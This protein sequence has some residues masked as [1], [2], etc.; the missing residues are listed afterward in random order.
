V[1]NATVCGVLVVILLAVEPV[2]QTL[3]KPKHQEISDVHKEAHA[4][5]IAI[6]LDG[7]PKKEWRALA[8]EYAADPQLCAKVMLMP[9]KRLL[10]MKGGDWRD[11]L[12]VGR[13]VI[14]P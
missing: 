10:P 5:C 6:L 11:R 7:K 12:D 9:D 14:D 2:T 1:I 13:S 8:I 3:L 4:E